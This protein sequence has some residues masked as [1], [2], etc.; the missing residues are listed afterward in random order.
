M[1]KIQ[2]K[3][4]GHKLPNEVWVQRDPG[5]KPSSS[6]PGPHP[7]ICKLTDPL[8]KMLERWR[9]SLDSLTGLHS[10]ADLNPTLPD[11]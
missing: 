1:G 3:E 2:T 5:R 11:P 6:K 4:K 10:T 8:M 7:R 9:I